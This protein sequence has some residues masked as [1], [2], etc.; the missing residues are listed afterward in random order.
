MQIANLREM[1]HR[2]VALGL[3][4]VKGRFLPWAAD[5]L[6]CG[7]VLAGWGER[8]WEMGSS[9]LRDEAVKMTLEL[10]LQR[11]DERCDLARLVRDHGRYLL[12]RVDGQ[13]DA[14]VEQMMRRQLTRQR[15]VIFSDER[16][17]DLPLRI[18]LCSDWYLCRFLLIVVLLVVLVV[19]L[20]VLLSRCGVFN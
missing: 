16:H 18:R 2:Q 6:L 8:T 10:V 3:R 19:V 13:R 14:R 5:L 4:S 11:W 9:V 12:M 17:D 20:S 7:R 15:V 1:R